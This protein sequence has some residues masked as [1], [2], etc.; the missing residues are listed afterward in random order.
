M[1]V[2]RRQLD[3]EDQVV[4]LVHRHMRLVSRNAADRLSPCSLASTSPPV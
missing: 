1:H 2:G 4:R 3:G